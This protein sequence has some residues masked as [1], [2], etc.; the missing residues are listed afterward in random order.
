[1]RSSLQKIAVTNVSGGQ[2]I[3]S[4]NERRIGFY[5]SAPSGTNLTLSFVSIPTASDGLFIPNANMPYY[6]SID[7]IGETIKSQWFAL[8]SSA[9]FAHV[10]EV[11]E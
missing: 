3:L 6:F 11:F 1:M 10:L 2:T 8:S 4:P 7:T 5:I 9:G